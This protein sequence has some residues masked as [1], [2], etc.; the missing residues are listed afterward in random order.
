[1]SVTDTT[2]R[3]EYGAAVERMA[4]R[5]LDALRG[6]E[7]TAAWS[8]PLSRAEAAA[9]RVLGADLFAPELAGTSAPGDEAARAVAEA[10][11]LFPPRP[12]RDLVTAWHDWATQAL[13]S[14]DGRAGPAPAAPPEPPPSRT[15]DADGWRQWTLA[16]ARL[17]PLALPGFDSPLHGTVR[18]HP[19]AMARGT[20]R[21]MLRRDH[22]T[23]ARLTRWLAWLHYT[24][25]PVPL[26]IAP[27]L[28]RLRQVG[29]GSARTSL[30]LALVEHLLHGH[31]EDR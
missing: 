13:A 31:K 26:E 11:R 18:A 6:A 27:L 12:D 28:T 5:V 15:P 17:A 21:A 2:L 3:A 30:D 10:Y 24:R 22:R 20:V 14:R 29:D 16:M 8:G 9:V 19:L 23:A 25:V 1:M 4:V 7:G